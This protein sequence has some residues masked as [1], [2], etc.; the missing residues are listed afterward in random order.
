MRHGLLQASFIPA[1]EQRD[2]RDLTRYRTRLVQERS[3][4][5][6]RLQGVLERANIKL[7]AVATDSW[8]CRPAPSWPP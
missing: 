3:R 2:L 6:N 4:E 8:G 5:V 1:L 7:A